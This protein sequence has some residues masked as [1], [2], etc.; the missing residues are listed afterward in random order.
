MAIAIKDQKA[1]SIFGE[2]ATLTEDFLS[3]DYRTWDG[4]LIS[5][6]HENTNDLLGGASLYDLEYEPE[7]GL[8]IASFAN[9][10]DMAKKFINSEFYQGL[11]QECIPLQ[12]KKDTNDVIKGYGT[13]VTIVMWPHQPAATQQMGVGVRPALAA[14]LASKYPTNHP[15]EDSM[16]EPKGGGVSA[17][18][19]E[20]FE[21]AVSENVQLKST[22]KVL[23]SKN[24]DMEKELDSWKQKYTDLESGEAD[25][26]KIAIS[27]ARK[28][29]DSELKATAEREA[30]VS[31]L[32]TVMS[33]EAY[34][35]YL[36]TNP[37]VEQI[38]SIAGIMKVNTSRGVGSSNNQASGTE[39]KSYEELD[40]MWNA[41]LG[42]A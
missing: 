10:P 9:L 16:T 41:K 1:Y 15:K 7:K 4:G 23:E 25:R 33:S 17:I 38:K 36:A 27:E 39:G 11:S 6:N 29:W 13:G 32:K 12:F 19:I 34:E 28:S 35:N 37:T 42:R 14:I 5:T 26:V 22:I 18:S 40:S 30:A 31:E 2:E 21:S 24:A 8:V 20:A 3:R